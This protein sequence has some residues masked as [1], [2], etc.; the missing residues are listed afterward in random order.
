MEKFDETLD[1]IEGSLSSISLVAMG[2]AVFAALAAVAAMLSNY[3]SNE[4][5]IDQV[6]ASSQWG[7]YQAKGIKGN[8]ITN[9]VDFLTSLGKLASQGDLD[10]ILQYKKEQDEISENAREKERSSTVHL[11]HQVTLARGVTL[12]Q[13]AIAL[14]AIALLTRRNRYWH[15]SLLAGGA[16]VF[17]LTQGLLLR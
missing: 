4:A 13:A 3:H 14:S 8:L 2:S 12:F 6:Q 7:Y 16:G 17:F 15:L 1:D 11:K 5:I 9:K 10:K